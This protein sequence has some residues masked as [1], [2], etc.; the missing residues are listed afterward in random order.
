MRRRTVLRSLGALATVGATAGC[1]TGDTEQTPR[2]TPARTPT[3]PTPTADSDTARET[4]T[5]TPSP[6][7]TEERSTPA[8]LDPHP[9]A[10][11]V[12]MARQMGFSARPAQ[13]VSVPGGTTTASFV[14]RAPFS[15][16]A[17]WY[18]T[19]VDGWSATES[20]DL[21]EA[22]E[23]PAPGALYGYRRLQSGSRGALVLYRGRTLRRFGEVTELVHVTGPAADVGAASVN[24][25]VY[26]VFEREPPQ[27]VTHRLV[28]VSEATHVSYFRSGYG[29]S[30]TND[31]E[32]CRSMKHYIS[33]DSGG[34]GE[35]E[36]QYAPTTGLVTTTEAEADARDVRVVI[37]PEGHP[38]FD[39]ELFHIDP[40][41][42]IEE[43]AQVTAGQKL[44]VYRFDS[45][46]VGEPAVNV[47]TPTGRT[48]VSY[49]E[50]MTDD[51][52]AEYEE[53]GVPSREEFV[54][55]RSYR[56]S[57]PI[58]CERDGHGTGDFL[59]EVGGPGLS[60]TNFVEL[61]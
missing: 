44:G 47:W 29:H 10:R 48:L 42:G 27:F 51:V 41:P 2:D 37:T 33:D 58:E 40:E 50:V 46:T 35:H 14:V 31:F 7:P 11:D 19:N 18:A 9:D 61:D 28:D 13:Y 52:F 3:E 16:V 49:F 15:E 21:R 5:E 22:Y 39:L 4:A 36:T 23:D 53:R 59:E 34:D 38:A 25:P 32:T 12:A 8:S 56:D 1:N 26:D 30:Y 54:L 55:G 6:T 43:G 60:E 45:Y 57:N 17:G 20:F 24:P